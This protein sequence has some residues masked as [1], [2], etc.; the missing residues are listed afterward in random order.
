MRLGRG[1]ARKTGWEGDCGC[2]YVSDFDFVCVVGDW[3]GMRRLTLGW[4]GRVK[5]ANDVTYKR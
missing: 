5:L 2:E 4:D 3:E 1:R